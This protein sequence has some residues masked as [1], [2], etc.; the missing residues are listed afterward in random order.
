LARSHDRFQPLEPR[1]C[2]EPFEYGAGLSDKR[3]RFVGAIL[4]GQPFRVLAESDGE[5]VRCVDLTEL[6]R[7]LESRLDPIG[8]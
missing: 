4:S 2:L 1:S 3:F 8:A 5:P 7:G 6:A